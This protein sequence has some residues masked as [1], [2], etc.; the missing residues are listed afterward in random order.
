MGGTKKC[1]LTRT[2]QWKKPQN[3]ISNCYCLLN[4]PYFTSFFVCFWFFV[5]VCLGVI[6]VLGLVF[7]FCSEMTD[8]S[9]NPSWKQLIMFLN[10]MLRTETVTSV[11]HV[12]NGV[13]SGN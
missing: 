5:S 12:F 8:A 10:A 3:Q 6:L 4:F 9:E 1:H 2:I 13:E 7:F 11:I